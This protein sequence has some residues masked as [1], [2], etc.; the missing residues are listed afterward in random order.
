LEFWEEET[1]H[2]ASWE[3][4][5]PCFDGFLAGGECR[6]ADAVRKYVTVN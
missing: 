1:W 2:G 3:D 6:G 4:G 5:G